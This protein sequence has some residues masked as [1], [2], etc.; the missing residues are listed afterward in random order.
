[1]LDV[2]CRSL[3]YLCF[4]GPGCL[5]GAIQAAGKSLG[6]SD[7]AKNAVVHASVSIGLSAEIQGFG[8]AVDIKVEG[9]DEELLKAGH[10][11]CHC[12]RSA[13]FQMILKQPLH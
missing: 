12:M 3:I 11:V 13:S 2:C 4:V 8:L 7:M 6:K 10:E 9:I 1:M 5:L